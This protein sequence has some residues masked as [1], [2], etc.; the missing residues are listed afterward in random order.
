MTIQ[1]LAIQ[2]NEVNREFSAKSKPELFYDCRFSSR[3]VFIRRVRGYY[4]VVTDFLSRSFPRSKAIRPG[5]VYIAVSSNNFDD[6]VECY[7]LLV[8]EM[9][10][11]HVMQL[12]LFGE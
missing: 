8:A 1:E 3:R 7:R 10:D 2:R 5:F 12:H 11:A 6:A 9:I 4:E